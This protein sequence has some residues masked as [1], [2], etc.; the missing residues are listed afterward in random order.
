MQKNKQSV[1]NTWEW[2]K[3]WAP[4]FLILPIL[5][6]FFA[7]Q[8][9]PLV[10]ELGLSF[11]RWGLL[12]PNRPF[13]GLSNYVSAF[14]D[15]VFLRALLNTFIYTGGVLPVTLI[16]VLMI[17]L[18]VNG[19]PGKEIFRTVYFIPVVTT[20]VVTGQVWRV[21]YQP[22]YG[23]LNQFLEFIGL[24]GVP[25]LTSP[26]TALLSIMITG[27]WKQFGFYM[28]IY[29][30]GLQTI[31]YVF[32]EAAYIDGIKP[33]QSLRHITIPLLK[34][35]VFFTLIIGII[36]SLQIFDLVFI[37]SAQHQAHGGPANSTMV[38]ALYIYEQGFKFLNMG[39]SAAMAFI[40]FFII[41]VLTWIQFKFNKQEAV[42]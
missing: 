11:F 31:P 20:M 41:S 8:I 21:M 35:V 32:Y 30:A 40:G 22:D 17:A 13:I 4:F 14:E 3:R 39:Y 9:V 6:L 19:I 7:I 1:L 15:P 18:L 34:P 2:R 16:L 5:L 24:H 29:L 33:L 38:Y 42:Y 28:V 12:E 10:S 26:N 23:V 25:W 36:G 27:V 37:M